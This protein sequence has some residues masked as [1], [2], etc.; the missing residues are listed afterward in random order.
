MLSPQLRLL[1]GVEVH[2]GLR[3]SY[4]DNLT[5]WLIFTQGL[6]LV[7]AAEAERQLLG[8]GRVLGDGLGLRGDGKR[9]IKT[10]PNHG[11]E[12]GAVFFERGPSFSAR[13]SS[14]SAGPRVST[15]TS[16]PCASTIWTASST[17]RSG[18][19]ARPQGTKRTTKPSVDDS[20]A[21]WHA[22]RQWWAARRA[23]AASLCQRAQDTRRPERRGCYAD[24]Y[25]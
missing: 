11:P 22:G 6:A 1:D 19:P 2:E 16:P 7:A 25:T 18:R 14:A 24:A 8:E 15:V 17:A 10:G 5:H 21:W 13:R 9:I 20:D 23:Y 12:E 3:N 4:Q